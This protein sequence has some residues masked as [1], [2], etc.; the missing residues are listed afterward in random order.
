VDAVDT[1]A[2][3][4]GF[5]NAG[6]KLTYNDKR[7]DYWSTTEDEE[8]TTDLMPS[9]GLRAKTEGVV[10]DVVI[11]GPVQKAGIAPGAK[12][13]SI[14]GRAFSPTVLREAAAS[15]GPLEFMVRSGDHIST[16]KVDYHGG[17]KYPHLDR[18]NNKPD[19]LSDIVRAKVP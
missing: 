17:E 16:H 11:G 18:E 10:E 5:E 15:D 14:D 9:L 6:W 12:I 4:A 7:S 3:V 13:T 8:K 2:P 1:H 19:L